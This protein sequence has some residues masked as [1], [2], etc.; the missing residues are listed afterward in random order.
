MNNSKCELCYECEVSPG[1]LHELGCDAEQCPY[2]GRHLL[3]CEHYLFGEVTPPPDTDR[4]PWT[5]EWPGEAECRE[6]GWFRADGC[7]YPA[8]DLDRF[9]KEAAWDREKKRFVLPKSRMQKRQLKKKVQSAR[10]R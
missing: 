2:C 7:C 4:L 8:L 5:G 9:L 1:Q 10:N 3:S 6:Y